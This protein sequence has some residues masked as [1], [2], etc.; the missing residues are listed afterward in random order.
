MN[1]ELIKEAYKLRFEYFNFF[2]DKELKWHEKYKKHELYN[3]V[4]ESFNYSYKDIA[5]V[6]PNLIE[7]AKN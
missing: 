2:E 5:K 1:D 4:V 3:I 6:M 7:K